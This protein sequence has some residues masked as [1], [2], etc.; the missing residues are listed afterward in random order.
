MAGLE[1]FLIAHAGTLELALFAGLVIVMWV[2]EQTVS[3]GPL[4]LKLKHSAVNALFMSGAL[5]VQIVMT[6]ACFALSGWVTAHQVGLLF[7]LPYS[8]SAWVKYGVLIVLMDALDYGYHVVMHRVPFLW[9]FHLAHH[10]DGVVDVS[11]TFRE[12]PG[13][14]AIRNGFLMLCV[15]LCGVPVAVLILR[16]VLQAASNI[17]AHTAL[18]LPPRVARV[19]G[20]VFMTPNLHHVHHHF[21]MPATN[22]NYAEIFSV[23]DRLFGTYREMARED[24]VFGLDTHMSG[25]RLAQ[26]E[27]VPA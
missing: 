5:P 10:T 17:F 12:H 22:S 13:E 18:T 9:R 27:R 26:A 20:W 14:T 6:L 11:T 8:G 1:Q 16:Q 23:W 21:R 3:A 7:A 24:I 15:V 2:L 25:E 4:G 19:V